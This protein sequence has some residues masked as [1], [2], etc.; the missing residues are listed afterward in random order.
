M[1][2]LTQELQQLDIK[3]EE[4]KQNIKIYNI[5]GGND[6]EKNELKLDLDKKIKEEEQKN[7]IL[8][9][10]YQKSLETIQ[11]IKDHLI[12]LFEVL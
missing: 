1:E 3:I 9:I 12:E 6:Q 2:E 7:K 10:Q 11:K 4:V 5:E 8:E